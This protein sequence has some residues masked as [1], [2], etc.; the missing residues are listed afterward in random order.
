M[1]RKKKSDPNIFV[2]NLSI[3]MNS[4][5]ELVL[6]ESNTDKLSE[7]DIKK[8]FKQIEEEN[9]RMKEKYF[10]VNTPIVNIEQ[11]TFKDLVK[12]FV[13]RMWKYFELKEEQNIYKNKI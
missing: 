7:E 5:K 12:V 13:I 2:Q 10:P 9:K 6:I 1:K 11:R 8:M 4:R 3:D